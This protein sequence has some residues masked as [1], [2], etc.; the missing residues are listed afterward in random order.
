M[1]AAGQPGWRSLTSAIHPRLT[2]C[3]RRSTCRLAL[4]PCRRAARASPVPR[5][6]S[7][8]EGT[9]RRTGS[10]CLHVL[11]RSAGPCTTWSSARGATRRRRRCGAGRQARRVCVHVLPCCS[12]W[13]CALTV[14]PLCGTWRQPGGV[15]QQ[16]RRLSGVQPAA[17]CAAAAAEPSTTQP[18][19]R[20]CSAHCP[21]A[22]RPL[23]AQRHQAPRRR[24]AQRRPAPR[25]RR[26]R[27]RRRRPARRGLRS[28]FRRHHRRR[29]R[30]HRCR[31]CSRAP[32]MWCPPPPRWPARMRRALARRSR[33]CSLAPW[34]QRCRW[35]P[36]RCA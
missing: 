26:R 30:R 18:K 15:R 14:H 32:P 24:P 9:V 7:G 1:P 34:R 3:G 25:R 5:T 33:R 23:P 20:R 28:C 22:L 8:S 4:P 27:L 10:R 17:S 31:L 29:R 6:P 21:P 36:P 2:L 35:T 19:H 16:Q 11:S 12:P 13:C